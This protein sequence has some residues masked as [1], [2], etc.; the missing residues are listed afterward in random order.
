VTPGLQSKDRTG[1][2][3]T[4]LGSVACYSTP[5]TT[6]AVWYRVERLDDKCGW[7]EVFPGAHLVNAHSIQEAIDIVGHHLNGD[8]LRRP[9]TRGF[10]Y[11]ITGASEFPQRKE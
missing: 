8:L 1:D 4:N 3:V 6:W 5:E 11:T 2:H 10:M 7:I 9:E